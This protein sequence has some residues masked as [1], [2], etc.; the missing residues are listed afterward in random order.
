MSTLRYG[1]VQRSAMNWPIYVARETGLFDRLGLSWTME[2][3][4]STHQAVESLAR[5]ELDLIHAIPDPAL[6]AI[7]EGASLSLIASVLT[8]P[9]YRLL[10]VSGIR[11][12]ADLKGK[13]LAI[14]EPGSAECLLLQHFL[15]QQG[16][17]T[18][19]FTWISAGPPLKR[20]RLLQDGGAEATMVSQ[21]FDFLLMDAG[22]EILFDS[23]EVFPHYPF[24][25]A[26]VSKDWAASHDKEVLLFL[27]VLRESRAWLQDRGNRDRAVD[28]L[29]RFTGTEEKAGFQTYDYFFATS[30][31]SSMEIDE[32][33][34][35]TTLQ[36]LGK[37]GASPG[38]YV[39]RSYLTKIE[40]MR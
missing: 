31:E 39:D 33:A 34:I 7:D 18:Q 35:A 19:D 10:A 40:T 30:G 37:P 23:R 12:S 16:F 2:I 22:C 17:Q 11:T 4:T 20:C 38:S 8:C 25:V 5:G 9:S 1:Q 3:F 15:L 28:I 13:R 24:A 21:P 36:L 26:V 14:N 29:C 6:Q 32:K 27:R